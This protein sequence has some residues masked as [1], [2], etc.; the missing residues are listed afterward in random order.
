MVHPDENCLNEARSQ[1]LTLLNYL[2]LKHLTHAPKEACPE[3]NCQ[4]HLPLPS[5]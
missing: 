4:R 5:R 2:N 1:Q 3:L